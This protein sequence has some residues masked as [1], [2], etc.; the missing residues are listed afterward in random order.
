M[1]LSSSEGYVDQIFWCS[2][3]FMVCMWNISL[4]KESQNVL[5]Q[6]FTQ[7]KQVEIQPR[8][9]N[10]ITQQSYQMQLL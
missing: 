9:K 7:K 1:S 3:D 5:N 8:L 6:S 10:S 4:L 2:V